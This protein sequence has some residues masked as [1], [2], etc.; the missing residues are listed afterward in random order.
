M[1]NGN[2]QSQSRPAHTQGNRQSPASNFLGLPARACAM[3]VDDHPG[4]LQLVGSVLGRLGHEVMAA[5][6]GPT[7]LRK[8]A[9]RQPDII[10]LDTLMP[11]MDGFE[12]CRRIR[13]NEEW[14]D[15]PIIFLSAADDKDLIVRALESGG[16]DYVVKP[17]NPTELSL[18]VQTHLTLKATCDRL[19]QLAE[20]KDELV[21]IVAHDLKNHLGGMQIS[22]QILKDRLGTIGDA[23]LANLCENICRSGKRLS[24]FL[25]EILAAAAAEHGVL[26]RMEPVKLS[27][28]VSEAVKE[29]QEAAGRKNLSIRSVVADPNATVCT[30]RKA[31]NQ[32]FDNLLSNAVKFS[33]PN[34]E[35]SIAVHSDEKLAECTIRDQGPGFTVEDKAGLFRRYNRLSARP[36]GGE[37]STGLGL[38]I[39]KKLVAEMKGELLLESS[40]GQGTAFT[41]RLPL[42]A[43]RA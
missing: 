6:D 2:F 38:S 4:N 31:L 40:P 15:I 21:G 18:R 17:F 20:D 33:P 23:R 34:H 11:E 35:I 7:A 28:A 5:G 30:D 41:V 13:E 19:R 37:P 39:V 26:S 22:A 9:I 16:V 29:Y 36:T 3:I 8:L 25:E 10:L 24:S 1:N 27:D 12:V 42:L 43:A 32:V 14:K